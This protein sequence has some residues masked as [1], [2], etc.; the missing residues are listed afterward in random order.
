MNGYKAF[1]KGKQIDVYAS[2][3]YEAQTKASKEFKAKKSYEVDVYLCEKEGKQ[4][5]HSTTTI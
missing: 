4:V 2:T 3:S 5:T 1:Y